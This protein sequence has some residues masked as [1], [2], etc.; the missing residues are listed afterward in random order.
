MAET[1]KNRARAT[2]RRRVE[3][4]ANAVRHAQAEAIAAA[5]EA[6]E[7]ER[8]RNDQVALQVAATQA[9]RAAKAKAR[10]KA[11]AE[12]KAK[13]VAEAKKE[14]NTA[15]PGLPQYAGSPFKSAKG[16]DAMNDGV[17][18]EN[19]GP[20][21]VTG[22]TRGLNHKLLYRRIHSGEVVAN[23]WMSLGPARYAPHARIFG[24]VAEGGY[25]NARVRWLVRPALLPD[26]KDDYI[27]S[28][29]QRTCGLTVVPQEA[30]DDFI[31]SIATATNADV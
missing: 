9:R 21:R 6:A 3:R 31:D 11:W 16:E 26:A 10:A 5:A 19:G 13:A 17:L 22:T 4:E 18:N 28:C 2:K 24:V 8:W 14:S 7:L 25:T 1:A 30:A 15:W 12:A 29:F 20:L 27:P 23:T